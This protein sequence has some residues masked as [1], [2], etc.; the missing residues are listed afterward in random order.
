MVVFLNKISAIMPK[1]LKNLTTY[2]K[3]IKII[4]NSWI[5]HLNKGQEY[6]TI[7][8]FLNLKA[9]SLTLATTI[10]STFIPRSSISLIELGDDLINYFWRAIL[11]QKCSC[12]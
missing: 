7:N 6:Y 2:F 12:E 10:F 3:Y 4:A 11:Q 5:R 9:V 8:I 1:K